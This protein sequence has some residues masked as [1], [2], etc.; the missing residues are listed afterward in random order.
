MG[1]YHVS[2]TVIQSLVPKINSSFGSEIACVLALPLSWAAFEGETTVNGY[3]A[4]II[5]P[6]L[7]SD[8]KDCWVVAWNSPDVNPIQK[9]SWHSSN[10]EISLSLFLFD[11]LLH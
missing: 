5:P 8:I 2:D 11:V 7:A 9:I 1:D 10:L 4:P 3:T 6:Q